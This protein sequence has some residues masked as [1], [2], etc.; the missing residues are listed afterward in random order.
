M[1]KILYLLI[2]AAH[3]YSQDSDILKIS[4]NNDRDEVY[5]TLN[6]V[7]QINYNSKI[8]SLDNF[9]ISTYIKDANNITIHTLSKFTPSN[10]LF[11]IPL[12]IT[13]LKLKENDF[14]QVEGV[15]NSNKDTIE[16]HS[17]Y[18]FKKIEKI[19]RKVKLDKYGRMYLNNELFF[20]LGIYTDYA[21]E[22]YLKYIN[23]SHLN[24]IMPYIQLGKND[25]IHVQNTQNG[26]I[27]VIY[28]VKS[29]YNWNKPSDGTKGCIDMEEEKNYKNILKK[30]NDFKDLPHLIGWYVND[31]FPPCRNNYTRNR[32][33]TFHQLDPDHPTLSV[34]VKSKQILPFM[35]S[36]DIM[37]FNVYPVG[38]FS[39][40]KIRR[41]YDEISERYNISM[42][43]KPMWAVTQIFDWGAYRRQKYGTSN[44]LQPPSMQ[45]MKSMAWQGFATGARGLLLYAFH[46][47]YSVNETT[48]FEPRWKD[49]IEFT[50]EIWK[51]KDLF[52]SIEEVDKI[53]YI[54][55]KNVAFK[56]WKVNNSNY[57]AVINL[58]RDNETFKVNLSNNCEI[59]KEF[60]LGTYEKKGNEI[61]FNLSPID[62]ILIKYNY[63]KNN[64]NLIIIIVCS[65][66]G[67][68]ILVVAIILI[69]KKMISRR[70]DNYKQIVTP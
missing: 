55:N 36:T 14:Y 10:S 59:N 52:L 30:I 58:E 22:R 43:A 57:I 33:L 42:K 2:F 1:L 53:E 66:V 25:L 60:G 35:D 54:E 37:G 9:I 20:P 11:T 19:E 5:D 41:V 39:K 6:I 70:D 50:D 32:T 29:V 7:Y 46:Q 3:I 23:Q 67:A 18:T 34:L 64:T 49:V 17:F 48:P 51:Y 28:N 24:F 26:K 27:K 40:S 63:N 69:R 47:M 15:L 16:S 56:Q 44:T 61:T 8:Y 21:Y 38:E 12:D 45:E 4:I 13:N 65:C 62:V 31:E 68:I